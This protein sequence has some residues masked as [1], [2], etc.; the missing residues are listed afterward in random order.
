MDAAE[1]YRETSISTQQRG[2]LIVMLYDGAVKFLRV[3]SEKLQEGDY[4]LKGVYIGKAQDIV[5]ELNNCLNVEAAP[6][7]ANDLR[8]IYN[9]IYRTLNE[10]NIERSEGKILAC[11]RI[12]SDLREAWDEVATQADVT[13]ADD[14]P[15]PARYSA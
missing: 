15:A 11:I 3:A 12:L 10:A 5:A 6:E 8:S 7:I 4:A 9:F 1:R 13:I 2:K 14:T